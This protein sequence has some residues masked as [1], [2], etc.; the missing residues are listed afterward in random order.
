MRSKCT[1]DMLL[2]QV[3]VLIISGKFLWREGTVSLTSQIKGLTRQIGFIPMKTNLEKRK[4][5][6]L[7]S[8]KGKNHEF[9]TK[10]LRNIMGLPIF[11]CCFFCRFNEFDH[12]FFGIN[13]TEANYMD[14]Q[15]KLLLQCAYRAL[16]DA[17][18]PL[19]KVS[20]T[21]TG[22]YIGNMY[23]ASKCK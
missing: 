8:S 13:E 19:E 4:Q 1:K 7:L 18:I 15:Q 16:E 12:K 9:I 20:G 11:C 23:K 21:R 17:G 2:S 22:V 6:K 5:L 10:H 3:R 14:P